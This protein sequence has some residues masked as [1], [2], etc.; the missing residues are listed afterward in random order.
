[1]QESCRTGPAM[2][3][4]KCVMLTGDHDEGVRNYFKPSE[5]GRSIRWGC[6]TNVTVSKS[7]TGSPTKA[8]PT[9]CS[10]GAVSSCSKTGNV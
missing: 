3:N 8:G 10:W 9:A 6:S 5:Q 2:S 4:P 7:Y 1:M